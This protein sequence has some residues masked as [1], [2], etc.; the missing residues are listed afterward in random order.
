MGGQGV[1][2]GQPPG[3]IQQHRSFVGPQCQQAGQRVLANPATSP[4]GTIIQ[5]ISGG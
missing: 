3:F 4:G 5:R 1:F 2:L